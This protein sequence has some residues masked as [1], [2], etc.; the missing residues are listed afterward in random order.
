MENH[1]LT[2]AT[3]RGSLKIE[4]EQDLELFK[5]LNSNSSDYYFLSKLKEIKNEILLLNQQKIDNDIIWKLIRF[6]TYI[7]IIL[8]LYQRD[9][10]SY[11]VSLIEPSEWKNPEYFK[12]I[13][14]YTLSTKNIWD[15]VE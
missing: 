7:G 14:K 12:Y 5:Q 3:E 6:K 2:F 11:F 9:D 8:Y 13:G 1:S 10:D 15:K 4:I